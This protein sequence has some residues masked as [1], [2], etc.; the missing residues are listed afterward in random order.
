MYHP[1]DFGSTGVVLIQLIVPR[2]C[3]GERRGS[4]DD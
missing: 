3:V 1:N 4:A 2:K